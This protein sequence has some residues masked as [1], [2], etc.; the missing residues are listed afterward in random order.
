V[1]VLKA[2]LDESYDGK[3]DVYTVAGF[4][5]TPL[6]W[7]AFTRQWRRV[8]RRFGVRVF[9]MA[10]LQSR[11]G[12]FKKGWSGE[13]KRIDF[14]QE[15]TA[16][17]ERRVIAGI[18][19]SVIVAD[20]QNVLVSQLKATGYNRALR[21]PYVY[22]LQATL[23]QLVNRANWK[24]QTACFCDWRDP[25]DRARKLARQHCDNLRERYPDWE[26]WL[27]GPEFVHK[28]VY[29]PLQAADLFAYEMFKHI[30][31]QYVPG[32]EE[33]PVRG[34]FRHLQKSKR[35]WGGFVNRFALQ[36]TVARLRRSGEIEFQ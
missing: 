30:D 35:M 9:H 16:I 25:K 36:N 4:I 26:A 15:L 3:G 32:R 17:I 6:K 14:L 13:Q 10:D 23:E 19:S 33:M 1:V 18:S 24:S 5:S 12:E 21:E 8:L 7:D 28:E 29:V 27:L 20:F 2:F 34:L 22:C 31:R 11:E